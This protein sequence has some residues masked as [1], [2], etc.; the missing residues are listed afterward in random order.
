V[1]ISFD[2]K[3]IEFEISAGSGGFSQLSRR[4]Y[5]IKHCNRYL[6][7][8]GHVETRIVVE[9]PKPTA[10]T[11]FVVISEGIALDVFMDRQEAKKFIRVIKERH[12]N[13]RIVKNRKQQ[14]K[15]LIG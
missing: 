11:F 14:N 4:Y 13:A 10:E 8:G 6:E 15:K 7:A 5:D 1:Q 9:R 2:G 3:N 12:P